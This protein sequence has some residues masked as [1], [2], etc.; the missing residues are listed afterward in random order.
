MFIYSIPTTGAGFVGYY[1]AT[2]SAPS[3]NDQRSMSIL[4]IIY[5]YLYII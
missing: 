3:L 1:Y 2:L 4:G 5:V